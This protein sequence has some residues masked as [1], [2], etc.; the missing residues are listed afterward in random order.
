MFKRVLMVLL[1]LFISGLLLTP[2]AFGAN[3]INAA[4]RQ[5]MALVAHNMNLTVAAE[6][7]I[8]D[9][10]FQGTYYLA[11][12][13][14]AGEAGFYPWAKFTLW[15]KAK[16]SRADDLLFNWKYSAY[17]TLNLGNKTYTYD[18]FTGE[19]IPGTPPT[20]ESNEG[21]GV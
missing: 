17:T 15:R 9:E 10:Y 2:Q 7:K 14:E 1:T 3:Y 13:K 8:N 19:N 18:V 11:T 12:T 21:K 5:K 16:M 6:K 20:Y 4:T